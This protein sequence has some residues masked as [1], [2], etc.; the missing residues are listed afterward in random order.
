VNVWHAGMNKF[1]TLYERVKVRVEMAAT[2]VF[3]HPNW[4]NPG[5]NASTTVSAGVVTGV[6]GVQGGSTGDKPGART[7]RA[8]FRLEF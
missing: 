4:S 7:L 6:G 2:N 3:N 1:F 8:G 5:T